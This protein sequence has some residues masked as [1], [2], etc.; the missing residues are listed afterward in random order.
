MPAPRGATGTHTGAAL[1]LSSTAGSPL[2]RSGTWLGLREVAGG[3]VSVLQAD[4]GRCICIK[5]LEEE[6]CRTHPH[7]RLLG[8]TGLLNASTASYWYRR[9]L[10]MGWRLLLL[11]LLQAGECYI[12][13]SIP[14]PPPPTYPGQLLPLLPALPTSPIVFALPFFFFFSTL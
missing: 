8:S 3:S 5:T 4:A 6:G 7:L 1:T 13:H 12:P 2:R 11:L 9:A 10:P 14:P